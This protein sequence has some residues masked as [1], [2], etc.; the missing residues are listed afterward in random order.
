[1]WDYIAKRIVYAFIVLLGVIV[2]V[3]FLSTAM[4]G[5]PVDLYLEHPYTQAD[6]DAV[7]HQLGLDLPLHER[8]LWY[9][10]NLLHGDL[11]TSFMTK[12]PVTEMIMER[13]PY[14]LYLAIAAMLFAI[15]ISIPLGIVA[16]THRGTASDYGTMLVSLLGVSMP[17]FWLGLILILI[18]ALWIPILPASGRA[19][20]GEL[21]D[22]PHVIL[23]AFALGLAFAG[24]NARLTRSS[25]L[26][27]LGQDYIRTA[28]AKGCGR[29]RILYQHALR[30]ALIPVVTH[31]GIQFAVLLGGAVVIEIVFTYNGLGQLMYN[32]IVWRDYYLLQGCILVLAAAFVFINLAVDILYAFLDPRIQYD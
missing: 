31:M 28:R 9:I 29:A 22:I 26:E 5:D 25:M 23:P 6:H 17:G 15:A 10:G 13:F 3:F 1:M 20:P 7:A 19:Y 18:F 16:A 8:L 11:G 30:N 4:P 12:R 14:T 32:A 24:S 2:F 27:V 21:W